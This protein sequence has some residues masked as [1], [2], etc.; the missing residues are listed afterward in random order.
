MIPHQPSEK[1]P[2]S[3]S[4]RHP[5]STK[6]KKASLS[7]DAISIPQLKKLEK[8]F[9]CGDEKISL[10][11]PIFVKSFQTV[12][13]E[14]TE[15]QLV[16]LFL[17]IDANADDE[18]SWDEVTQYLFVHAADA[19]EI[20]RSEANSLEDELS[21]DR[22]IKCPNN[23]H[24]YNEKSSPSNNI[25]HRGPVVKILYIDA[26]RG[27]YLTASLDGTVHSWDATTFLHRGCLIKRETAINDI[28]ML[29]MSKKLVVA[30]A[31][32]TLSFHDVNSGSEY[33][34]VSGSRLHQCTPT[35]I[36]VYWDDIT[37]NEIL[38]V[39]DDAG[40]VHTFGLKYKAWQ[41]KDVSVGPHDT[42]IQKFEHV[43]RGHLKNLHGEW[44]SKIKFVEDLNSVVTCSMDG[45][46]KLSD[47]HEIM[48]GEL[49]CVR[50]VFD[51]HLCGVTDFAWSESNRMMVSAGVERGPLVW[52]PF[53]KSTVTQLSA[54]HASILS[55]MTST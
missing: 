31:H 46:V 45:T 7:R 36:D 24:K 13:P 49:T 39:G 25:Y 19:D 43:E 22:F 34:R 23:H 26:G 42:R 5:L 50:Y 35:C 4:P 1:P 9:Q 28:V 37:R 17:K 52:N 32:S 48:R 47:L 11:E 6:K 15:P 16:E 55:C 40:S 20:S 41:I 8:L 38:I 10:N 33:T 44:I 30:E 12:I 21:K 51:Q 14:L 53:S 18:V 29:P 27:S 3:N 2:S 54:G